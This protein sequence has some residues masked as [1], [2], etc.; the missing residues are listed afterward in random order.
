MT[1]SQMFLKISGKRQ[2]SYLIF[3]VLS[4]T[5]GLQNCFCPVT[6]AMQKLPG[7]S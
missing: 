6:C 1:F 4:V 7:A 3:T 2:V 5:D